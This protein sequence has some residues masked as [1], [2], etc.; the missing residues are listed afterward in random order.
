MFSLQDF[1]K[2]FCYE[3]NDESPTF[4]SG[5]IDRRR[6]HLN[7]LLWMLRRAAAPLPRW[8]SH[9][10]PDPEPFEVM[11][12]LFPKEANRGICHNWKLQAYSKTVCLSLIMKNTPQGGT[13]H[14]TVHS[15]T[16]HAWQIC[17][18]I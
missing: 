6:H 13:A 1:R 12:L 18:R 17:A 8:P 3:Q 15:N 7:W 16:K 11:T 5:M 10:S 2:T 14:L 4:I 9:C